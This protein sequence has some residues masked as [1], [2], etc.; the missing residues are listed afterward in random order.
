MSQSENNVGEIIRNNLKK[1]EEAISEGDASSFASLFLEDAFMKF[2]GQEPLEGRDA[3]EMAN[4]QMIKDGVARLDLETRE[5]ESFGDFAYEVGSYELFGA[6]DTTLDFGNYL[7]IWKKTGDDWKIHRD[8]ISSA[9][10]PVE[11]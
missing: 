1:M 5:I 11:A 3:I 8:L 7:T 2:P 4:E 9:Q 6:D 10:A